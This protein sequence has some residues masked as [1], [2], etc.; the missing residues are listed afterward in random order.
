MIC[1][2]ARVRPN[3]ILLDVVMAEMDGLEACRVIKRRTQR[4]R[5]V[6]VVLMS[7]AY[8]TEATKRVICHENGAD[9]FLCKPGDMG[10]LIGRVAELLTAQAA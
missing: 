1:A 10:R 6:R 3:L 8:A 5:D 4:F 7:A 2:M 9:D